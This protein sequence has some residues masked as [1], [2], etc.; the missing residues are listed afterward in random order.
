MSRKN[1][2]LK[3]L[4]C[5]MMHAI[6]KH[7]LYSILHLQCEIMNSLKLSTTVV[8]ICPSKEGNFC[9]WELETFN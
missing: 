3:D 9:N 1:Y 7:T 6:L 4:V 8:L 2:I 5:L